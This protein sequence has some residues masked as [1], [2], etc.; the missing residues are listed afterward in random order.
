MSV[1]VVWMVVVV[2]LGGESGG[3]GSVVTP[4]PEPKQISPLGQHPSGTQ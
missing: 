3:F 1:V 2:V 4:G